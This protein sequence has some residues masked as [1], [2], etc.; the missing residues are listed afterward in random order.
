MM[1]DFCSTYRQYIADQKKRMTFMTIPN[2][3]QIDSNITYLNPTGITQ[4]IQ[5][6]GKDLTP[7]K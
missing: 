2:W 5:F 7:S 6:I 1:Y 4:L 3:P